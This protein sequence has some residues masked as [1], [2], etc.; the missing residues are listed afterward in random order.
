MMSRLR[1]HWSGGDRDYKPT[2]N[3][4][5]H[6]VTH[7]GQYWSCPKCA[8]ISFFAQNS[9]THLKVIHKMPDSE[10]LV[11]VPKEEYTALLE[12]KTAECFPDIYK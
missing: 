5:A 11:S 9:K 4:L 10:P 3:S 6:A 8:H 7:L 12:E 2:A 1:A